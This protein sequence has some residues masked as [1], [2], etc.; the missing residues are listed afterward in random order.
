MRTVSARELGVVVEEPDLAALDA[1]DRNAELRSATSA[2]YAALSGI[3]RLI[4]TS[5]V[6]RLRSG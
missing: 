6:L 2:V 1:L 4:A 3:L 5:R